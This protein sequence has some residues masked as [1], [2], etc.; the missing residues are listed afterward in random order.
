MTNRLLT[1]WTLE[2]PSRQ[3]HD[4]RSSAPRWV[5]LASKPQTAKGCVSVGCRSLTQPLATLSP[6]TGE[7]VHEFDHFVNLTGSK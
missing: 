6:Q 3:V 7:G 5:L 2:W 1:A 4:A